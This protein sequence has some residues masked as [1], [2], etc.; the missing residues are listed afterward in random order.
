MYKVPG[1]WY[2]VITPVFIFYY[3]CVVILLLI[4][5]LCH[6]CYK[7]WGRKNWNSKRVGNLPEFSH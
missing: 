5:V 4:R 6:A 3:I 2:M 1:T 7:C